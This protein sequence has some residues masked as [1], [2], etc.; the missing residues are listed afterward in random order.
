MLDR[1]KDMLI[2]MRWLRWLMELIG[3]GVMAF[4]VFIPRTLQEGGEWP[5]IWHS[6]YFCLSKPLFILGMVFVIL[7]PLLGIKSFFRTILDTRLFNF[8]AKISFCTYLVHLMVIYQFYTS[9]AYDF[10]YSII[11]GFTIYVGCLVL[12]CLVGFILTVLLELPCAYYQKEL[13][14]ALT[15]WNKRKENLEPQVSGYSL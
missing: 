1:I 4:L 11:D 6:L 13:M 12:S 10:Y 3:L 9:R 8:I 15:N 7:P 14:K 5:Q 2:R